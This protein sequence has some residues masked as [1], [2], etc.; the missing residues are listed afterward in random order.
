[1]SSTDIFSRVPDLNYH[2]LAP[3]ID[4]EEFFK[5]VRSRR[6]IRLYETEPIPEAVVRKCL[7]AA[8][9]A[10]NSSNL[11]SWELHWVRSPEKKQKLVEACLSQPAARSA[12]ELVVFVART[13]TWR[14]MRERMLQSFAKRTDV[15]PSALAYYTKLIPIVMTQGPLGIIGFGKKIAFFL[16]GFFTPTPREPTSHSDMKLWAAKTTALACENYMLAMRAC[17]YDTCPMEGFDSARLKSLLNLPG[18]AY[19]TMVISAGKR[20]KG[21]VYGPQL[22]FEDS[23]FIK[24]H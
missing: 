20:A 5:V 24:E 7:K 1:M 10:P 17:G 13:G 23:L 8:L 18:D 9:L 12:A 2:E 3:E 14:E 11:Q 16:R 22:R 21:G 19:I 6:S 15:P 4:E